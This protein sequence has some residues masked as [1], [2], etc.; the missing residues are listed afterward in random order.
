MFWRALYF[1]LLFTL[2]HRAQSQS[3]YLDWQ[4][5]VSTQDQ[6]FNL[7]QMGL[8][9]S[10][11]DISVCGLEG[12]LVRSRDQSPIRLS[13]RNIIPFSRVRLKMRVALLD[14]W[15]GE[16][17]W[18]YVNNEE[19]WKEQTSWRK[20]GSPTC[21]GPYSDR[22]IDVSKEFDVDNATSSLD[23]ILTANLKTGI[24]T[25]S[26]GFTQLKID[27]QPTIF[28]DQSD[29]DCNYTL[30]AEPNFQITGPTWKADQT[31]ILECAN[32]RQFTCSIYL[33]GCSCETSSGDCPSPRNLRIKGQNASDTQCCSLG[34]SCGS[35]T[36]ATSLPSTEETC[37]Y[38]YNSVEDTSFIDIK[39]GDMSKNVSVQCGNGR[40]FRCGVVMWGKYTCSFKDKNR[41]NRNEGNLLCPE[42]R[43]AIVSGK[44]CNLGK[45][46]QGKKIAEPSTISII[47]TPNNATDS[48]ASNSRSLLSLAAFCGIIAVGAVVLGLLIMYKRAKN[49]SLLYARLP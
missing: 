34:K 36:K 37:E 3:T 27:V 5:V 21:F 10:N 15:N 31:P 45:G 47:N 4:T 7:T 23:V 42:P 44:C 12:T 26:F 29:F 20:H 41:V 2:C 13:K 14:L 38:V 8:K 40:V 32:N 39:V 22:F 25:A 28:D 16:N 33:G 35:T 11:L 46:C 43:N 17:I 6:Q 48:S 9:E 30:E 49:A 24:A 19:V 1:L 18:L